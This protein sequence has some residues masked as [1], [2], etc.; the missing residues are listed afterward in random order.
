MIS[1]LF[2]YDDWALLISRIVLG[3]VLVAHGLPKLKGLSG[4]A[5]WFETQGFKPGIFWVTVVAVLEFFGGIMLLAGLLT[6]VI[7]VLV[8][9]QFA[10][11]ILK[12]NLRKGLVGGYELDLLILAAAIVSAVLGAGGYSLDSYFSIFLFPLLN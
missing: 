5:P 2:L 1:Y 11:V 3:A 9:I 12:V 4:M 7:A 6:Q 10:V 8:A